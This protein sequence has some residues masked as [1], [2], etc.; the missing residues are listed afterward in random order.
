MKPCGFCSRHGPK[1]AKSYRTISEDVTLMVNLVVPKL[2]DFLL[3]KLEDATHDKH[4]KVSFA[5]HFIAF[6]VILNMAC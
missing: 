3:I 2:L 6:L 5:K 1:S 4:S